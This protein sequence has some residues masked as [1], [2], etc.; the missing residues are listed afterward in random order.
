MS[1]QWT[2]PTVLSLVNKIMTQNESSDAD[3]VRLSLAGDREAFGRL[4]DRHARSVRAVVV[5]VSGDF[6]AADDLTQ[7]TFLRGY[8]RLVTLRDGSGFGGWIRG[9]ARLVAKE[10]RRQIRREHQNSETS[11]ERVDAADEAADAFERGEE[12][13]RV[14]SAVAALPERERLVVHAY[15]FHEQNAEQ[16]AAV[17]GI[18]RS[19]FYVA[20]ERAIHRLRR[21]LG[22]ISSST[23][24]AR[25]EQ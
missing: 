3:D 15:Y 11:A 12:Q 16:A 7:E 8:R 25:R 6:R 10:Q 24:N 17:I 14:L 13:A 22:V 20:L 2:L 19:G 5:A 21:Q 18:S 4:Y 9:V 23:P 1:I